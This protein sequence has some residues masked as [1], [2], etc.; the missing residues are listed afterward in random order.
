MPRLSNELKVGILT[1]IALGLLIYGLNY[2]KGTDLFSGRRNYYAIYHEVNGLMPDNPVRMN[3][4]KVG[5]VEKISFDNRMNGYLVVE[6]TVSSDAPAIPK[7][8]IARISSLD[9]LGAKAVVIEIGTSEEFAAKGDTILSALQASLQDEVNEQVRPLKEKA[10]E[11]L[12]SLDSVM[13]VLRTVFN[14]N[15]RENLVKSF[16][17]IKRSIEVFERNTLRFDTLMINEKSR[18]EEILRNV[19][20]ITKNIKKHNDEFGNIIENFSSFSDSLAK[21]DVV[22]TINNTN[23]AMG[24]FSSIMEKVNRGEG[25]LGMLVKNDSLYRSVEGASSSLNR[26]LK[27]MEEH[28][29]R[30]VHFS[31]FGKKDKK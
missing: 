10:E 6:I 29:K 4:F 15:A 18:I 25:T 9:L 26:L 5:K 8:S 12:S 13:T 2:L 7:N 1:L 21:S 28:P 17:S 20:A 16:A 19:D 27:D 3:G 11:M 22:S 14:E 30:Y 31:V 24:Q 23:K